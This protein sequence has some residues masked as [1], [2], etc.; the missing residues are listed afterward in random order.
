M[1]SKNFFAAS[2]LVVLMLVLSGCTQIPQPPDPNNGMVTLKTIKNSYTAGEELSLEI[3]NNTDKTIHFYDFFSHCSNVYDYIKVLKRNND[4]T[5]SPA[6]LIAPECYAT[7]QTKE[8]LAGRKATFTWNTSALEEGVYKIE[9]QYS[10]ETRQEETND[11]PPTPNLPAQERVMRIQSNEF[12]VV[13]NV[14]L[15]TTKRS[16]QPGETIE[17]QYNGRNEISFYNGFENPCGGEVKILKKG[18]LGFEEVTIYKRP[19][20][21]PVAC[22]QEMKYRIRLST[23]EKIGVGQ[24]K[25]LYDGFGNQVSFKGTYKLEIN[26]IESNE[27]EIEN[28][29]NGIQVI[30]NKKVY[31]GNEGVLIELFNYSQ[32]KI[33]LPE[34][35]SSDLDVTV[36]KKIDGEFTPVEIGGQYGGIIC[37]SPN[38]NTVHRYEVD[39][40]SSKQV[41]NWSTVVESSSVVYDEDGN[42]I[43]DAGI[44]KVRVKYSSEFEVTGTDTYDNEIGKPVPPFMEVESN[45]FEI[46][47]GEQIEIPSDFQVTLVRQ[48]CFGTCPIYTLTVNAD[49][50]VDYNGSRFV[51]VEGEQ[52]SKISLKN[53]KK[54]IKKINEI[55]YFSLNNEYTYNATFDVGSASTTVIMNGKTKSILH[56][57]EDTSAPEELT[58][59]EDFIDEITNSGAF[60]VYF[61]SIQYLS[62]L[63]KQCGNNPWDIWHA[64]LN[65]VYIQPPTEE[66]ILKEY[67]QTVQNIE[68]IEYVNIPNQYSVCLSC[69][70]ARGDIVKVL[71]D[72][73]N[74]ETMLD[75]GWNSTE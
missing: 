3:E 52:S 46:L 13:G 38:D 11:L 27:F 66:Q 18:F 39:L 49:G 28:N 47:G 4:G 1:V 43:E 33:Y 32:N 53:V 30:T 8:L 45:E 44:Y 19:V 21:E 57:F 70:C 61:D 16:Y 12:T 59:F 63:P 7:P 65:R 10:F 20:L 36:L 74:V 15:E 71:V 23:G 69:D 29:P 14:E 55:N 26:G 67:Y 35:C 24:F 17:V 9:N 5:F 48:G 51:M 41:F 22:T 72:N 54:L 50:S 40:K 73:E 60:W 58:E 68:V 2:I 37:T 62:Y 56:A 34:K 64:D 6:S 25:K 42:E 31:E 75:L